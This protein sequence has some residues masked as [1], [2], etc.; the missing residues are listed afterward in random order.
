[1][2]RCILIIALMLFL[3]ECVAVAAPARLATDDE[4]S[5][6]E[7]YMQQVAAKVRSEGAGEI[8]YAYISTTMFRRMFTSVATKGDV[9]MAGAGDFF[10]SLKNL[11]RFE[12]ATSG[13]YLKLHNAFREFLQA[14][15]TVMGM[16]LVAMNLEDNIL[17][18]V[19]SDNESL[20]MINDDSEDSL[21]NVVFIVGLNYDLFNQLMESGFDFG[22]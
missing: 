20:L 1:M 10:G 22:F 17:T 3:S 14:N 12:T 5:G 4:K 11:R 7:R 13:G 15:E 2:K 18:V 19:Y 16:E 6:V 21:M 8:N 9:Y